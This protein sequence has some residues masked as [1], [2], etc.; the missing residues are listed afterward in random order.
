MN[1]AATKGQ[2]TRRVIL[3]AGTDLLFLD[4][5]SSLRMQTAATAAGISI[6]GLTHHFPTKE[7]LIIGILESISIKGWE[8]IQLDLRAPLNDHPL[9]ALA[10][11][12]ERFF[13]RKEFLIYLDVYLSVRRDTELGKVAH[14]LLKNQRSK[15]QSAWAQKLV[16]YGYGEQRAFEITRTVWAL[17]R[18]LAI[19]ASGKRTKLENQQS[20]AILVSALRSEE[21]VWRRQQGT[22]GIPIVTGNKMQIS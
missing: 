3:D 7:S 14:C 15:V 17:A 13:A 20:L 9:V 4:G 6:G 10:H 19:S 21:K 5:Y 2:R 11:S 16:N 1:L 8:L 22:R 12:A 18:G